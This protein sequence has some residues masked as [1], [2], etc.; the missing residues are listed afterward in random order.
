LRIG[1][2]AVPLNTRLTA[3]ER[4]DLIDRTGPVLFFG[5]DDPGPL[6]AAERESPGAA[7]D[8][9]VDAESPAILLATSGSTGKSKIVVWSHRTLAALHLSGDGRGIGPSDVIPVMTPLMHASGIYHLLTALTQRA[10]VVLIRS[11]DPGAVL[12]AVQRH[13]ITTMFGLPF[14]CSALA[15]EQRDRP[16]DTSTLRYGLVAGDSLPCPKSRATH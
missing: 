15:A 4:R 10:V 11:F 5:E 2:V 12:D 1:S 13:G 7:I 3:P 8:V 16:R 14:M 6:P 9:D